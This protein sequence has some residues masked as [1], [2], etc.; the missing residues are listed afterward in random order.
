[1]SAEART[2][3]VTGAGSGI[4]LAT[5][6][7]LAADGHHVI[8]ADLGARGDR[9]AEAI[10]AAGG[11]A[12]GATLDVASDRSWTALADALRE[13]GARLGALV[14]NAGV[15]RDRTLLKMSEE[16]FDTVIGVH[17]KGSWLGCRAML[18]LLREHRG[19]AIVNVSSTGR[20]GSFGQSNYAAA[21]A[22][23]V[24]LTKT[25]AIEAARYG[26]RCNAV[27]PGAVNTPM[28]ASVPEE[29]KR[30][31]LDGI[32]LGRFAEPEE[33]ASAIS[34]LISE[35]ASYVTGHVLDVNGSEHHA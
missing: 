19:S 26:V 12:A 4:G 10:R 5:A 25:I 20:H 21:K 6:T 33:I 3:V 14:N 31:W 11:S 18:P 30:Q 35:D 32:P 2:A 15:T 34:F 1:M 17:L 7:R 27:A 22:G 29:T 8:C 23:I 24:G 9:T 13:H 16:E 28:L